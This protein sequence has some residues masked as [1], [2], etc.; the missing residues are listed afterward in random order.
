[1][2]GPAALSTSNTGDDA[3]LL[4]EHL[5]YNNDNVTRVQ[6]IAACNDEI[7]HSLR[8]SPFHKTLPRSSKEMHWIWVRFYEMGVIFLWFYMELLL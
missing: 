2:V 6:S 8:Y 1:M 5:K 7:F 3:A 4:G